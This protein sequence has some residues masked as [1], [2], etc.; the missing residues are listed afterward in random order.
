VS[1]VDNTHVV[2]RL[3]TAFSNRDAATIE[4]VL[5]PDFVNVD[6][7]ALPGVGTDRSGVVVAMEY[8][9]AAF[10]GARAELVCVIAD[11]DRVAVHDR[12][13]GTH[14]G[15]FQGIAPT[16]REIDVDFIHLFRVVDGLIVER[17]G[18]ADVVTL[19]R[20]LGVTE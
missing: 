13:R 1:A 9:H 2:E 15:E 10:D 8:L 12:L 5:A 7:P 18:I 20:Q 4:S 11:G 14:R 6:P 17:R 16:G 3:L 19:R